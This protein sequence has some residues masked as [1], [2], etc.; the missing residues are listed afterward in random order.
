MDLTDEPPTIASTIARR[1]GGLALSAGLAVVG[2]AAALAPY[3]AVYLVAVELFD[4]PAGE[5]VDQ[6]RVT[7]I[8][9]GTAV[10][11]V[12]QAVASGLSSHV[13]HVAAYRVLADLRTALVARIGAMPLGRV[14]ARSSGE[15]K[16]VLHDDVEQLE[17]ALAHGVP[18]VA[19]A[20][21]VP[22]ATTVLLFAVDWRLA[23]LALL[24]L[25]LLVVAAGIGMSKA[26]A[27]NVAAAEHMVKVNGAVM[28]YLRGIK[29]IRGFLRPDAGYDQARQA[30]LTSVELADR[31]RHSPVRW[32][33]AAMMVA[34]GF[35]VLLLLPAGGSWY[36]SGS[37]DLPTLALFLLLALGYLTPLIGLVGALATVI[38]RAQMAGGAIDGLL[39][40][41]VL[42][43]PATP[44]RPERHDVAFRGVTFG[45]DPERPVLHGLDLAFPAGTTTALVGPTGAGKSTLARLV[46]RWWDVDDG[47]VEIGGV[48]VRAI[49]PAELAGLVAVVQQD[50]YVFGATL[51]ENVRI[52]RPDADDETVE[53]AA[54]AARL[55]EVAAALPQGWDTPL[56]SGGGR[57][58]GGERQRISIARALLKDAPVVVL[59]EATASLD[60][61]N[62]AAT[63]EALERLT[64]G[65]TVIAIAHRLSTVTGADEIVVIDD[66][67][68]A[69]RGTHD[70]L[71]SRDGT[72]RELWQAYTAA[73]GWR[74]DVPDAPAAAPVAAPAE[75]GDDDDWS[76]A[77]AAMV[78]PGVGAMTFGR[79]WRT[80]YG[81]GWPELR[82]RGLWRLV[83]EALVRGAPLAV[84]YLLL[85]AVVDEADGG[86]PVTT[87]LVWALTGALAL[88]LV[89]RVVA[90]E[91]ANDVVWEVAA[92]AKGDL[93]LSILDR[94]RR[95]PLGFFDRHDSAKVQT[96]VTNDVVMVDFQNVPQQ[97]AAAA[98]QPVYATVVLL[99]IDWRLALAAVVGIPLF[100]VTAWAAD[101]TY[102]RVFAP[103]HRTR[104]RSTR[105]LL[106]HVRG[107][108][109]LRAY[110]DSAP[111][112]AHHA[113]IEDL[114]R[115]SVDM[116]VRAMPT[117]ALGSVA[118]Q[119]GLVVLIVV[120]AALYRSDDVDAATLLL[121]LVVALALYQPIQELNT[122]TGYRR[123]QQ[124]I[125]RK[126]AEV[127]DAPVLPEPDRPA[128]PADAS[129]ELRD[130]SFS[131]EPAG[132]D[133]PNDP[134][135]GDD[136]PT[137]RGVSFTARP[138]TVT[139]LVGPSGAGKSTIADLIAREWD[140]DGG[141]VLIGGADVRDLGSATVMANVATVYQDVHLFADTVRANVTLGRPDATDAE[142]AAALDAAQCADVVAAL[143][144]GLDTVVGEG[145]A[146]LSGGQRQRLS[147]ARALL[148][149]APVVILDEAASAVDPD[150]EAR[151]QAALGRLM[152]GRT[153]I[154]IAHRLATVA[155]ADQI[156]VLDDGTV[157]GVGPHDELL[158]T[159]PTYRRLWEAT[160]PVASTA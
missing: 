128:V 22:L 30:V 77:A 64:A 65:R 139:A 60:A 134:D 38:V 10:A 146:T 17:E 13:A 88:A 53:A 130:V 151:I 125:G 21:A 156:V 39:A 29:V 70:E 47:A 54:T 45:Y 27:D 68:V 66:G 40:E 71:L 23:L 137:V 159:S 106:E 72:Y 24:A 89:L 129:V 133:D 46:A 56:D 155:G 50:E 67:A 84:V 59:D 49:D 124:Q 123:N 81:R 20:A 103:L 131:Y 69:E 57:L 63:L 61:A 108:A 37:V 31:P 43:A 1:R 74:I 52:A 5:P 7:A 148:K 104:V 36:V 115:A 102:E 82:R 73:A 87:G 99:V 78:T 145:G 141:A 135:G 152:A 12:V 111:A 107:A 75:A 3:V 26:Q 122:L 116:S 160:A 143:P 19:S 33:V 118:V 94:L 16:K 113:A 132:P 95:V 136:A 41:P 25:V 114:R 100:L 158:A 2:A 140:V 14:Q 18:D 76:A 138:G 126:V 119:L 8:A 97:V 15:M 55:D 121:F 35:A 90:I 150:T 11:L 32:I 86:E 154:V 34:T 157:D 62:E 28:S 44:R 42:E 9:V 48:D 144:D 117:T 149:D 91:R 127:W 51:R 96:L 109:A 105:T 147:I 58:S 93:Q 153:V 4:R 6:G 85:R 80:L 142:V 98:I 79:Q 110:P 112:R 92:R 120:G 101:R 83:A